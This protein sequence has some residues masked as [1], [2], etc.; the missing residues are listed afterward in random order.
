MKQYMKK[1][2]DSFYM[3]QLINILMHTLLY[4]I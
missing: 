2:N 1:N 3:P 4:T